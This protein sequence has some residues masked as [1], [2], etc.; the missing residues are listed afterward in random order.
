M[1]RRVNTQFVLLGRRGERVS[2]YPDHRREPAVFDG[3][4]TFC[5]V[6]AA[7]SVACLV[8]ALVLGSG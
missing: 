6:M 7:I 3:T 4:T 1:Q 8:A 2:K 5:M